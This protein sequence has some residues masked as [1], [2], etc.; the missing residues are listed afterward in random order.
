L[1]NNYLRDECFTVADNERFREVTVVETCGTTNKT[2][3]LQWAKNGKNSA[4][5]S[6]TGPFFG[7]TLFEFFFKK[8]LILAFWGKQ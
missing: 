1:I 6:A 8:T 3:L 4:I 7:T 5:D 2:L